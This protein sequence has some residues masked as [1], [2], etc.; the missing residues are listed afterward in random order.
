MLCTQI[1]MFYCLSFL[2]SSQELLCG[3]HDEPLMGYNMQDWKI[4]LCKTFAHFHP[5]LQRIVRIKPQSPNLYQLTSP[6]GEK[7]ELGMKYIFLLKIIIMHKVEPSI[8]NFFLYVFIFPVLI[9]YFVSSC[10]LLF[11]FLTLVV[12]YFSKNQFLDLFI[13]STIFK[14]LL[15]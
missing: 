6:W 9:S 8:F 4:L 7:G 3:F 12:Y 15:C 1:F 5:E 10:F 2:N 13:S 11:L 14:S